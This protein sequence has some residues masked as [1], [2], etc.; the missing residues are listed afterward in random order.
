MKDILHI[1]ISVIIFCPVL[2]FVIVYAVSRKVNI[3]GTHAFGAASD[4]TTFWLFF[5]VP[6]AIGALWGVN[7][8]ALLVMLAIVLAIVF[9]YVDWRTKKE[10]EVKPLLRKIWRFLFLVL[11]TAYLLIC[12]VGMIQ[13]VVEYLQSV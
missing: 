1:V 10:I 3:R 8:G 5:S 13:S 7:V 2:L 4:V 9:T 12:L 11:S 6:L